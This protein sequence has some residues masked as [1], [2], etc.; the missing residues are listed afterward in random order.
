MFVS[1]YTEI[2][3]YPLLSKRNTFSY[4]QL[5]E[6]EYYRRWYA[7]NETGRHLFYIDVYGDGVSGFY[8]VE[9][10]LPDSIF[11]KYEFLTYINQLCNIHIEY[12]QRNSI[13]EVFI[14]KLMKV[15]GVEQYYFPF[16]TLDKYGH[17]CESYF[18]VIDE[19][20]ANPKIRELTPYSKYTNETIFNEI[21]KEFSDN[22]DDHSC[23]PIRKKDFENAIDGIIELQNAYIDVYSRKAKYYYGY[24]VIESLHIECYYM[25]ESEVL[26]FL[27]FTTIREN[28]NGSN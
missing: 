15:P 3:S 24:E 21:M 22:K 28:P 2:N 25:M 19:I 7:S 9:S 6:N 4:L 10:S 26:V 17:Y 27:F 8:Y 18:K 13:V 14:G 20:I 1:C 23:M 11:A 16:S 12:L 5:M